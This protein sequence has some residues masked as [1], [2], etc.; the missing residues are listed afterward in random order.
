MATS[1]TVE[2]PAQAGLRHSHVAAVLQAAS[3]SSHSLET[4]TYITR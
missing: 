1:P 4:F 2:K 3:S